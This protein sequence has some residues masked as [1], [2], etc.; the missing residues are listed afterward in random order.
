LEKNNNE[1]RKE[2]L[3]R[4]NSLSF[5]EVNDKTKKISEKIIQMDCF[6]KAQKIFTYL[7]FNNEAGTR[8]LIEEAWK[9]GKTVGVPKIIEERI[10][11][12]LF[13]SYNTLE[14]G[15]YGI[16]VPNRNE[17]FV[18]DQETLIIVPGVAFD[19]FGNRIG[20]GKGYYDRFLAGKTN[21][22]IGIAYDFQIIS[23]INIKNTDIPVD[24]IITESEMINCG[25]LK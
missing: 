17:Y 3:F 13:E 1:I 25:V 2:I 21:L 8:I 19:R 9:R 6:Q 15:Q 24:I 11:P 18:L 23:S 20:F 22:K 5:N 12:F 7:D 14:K 16:M 10:K 4:R